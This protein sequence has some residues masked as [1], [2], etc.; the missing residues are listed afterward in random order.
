VAS[1]KLA[2]Y[3]A[4][5]DF[6][7]T[8]E[9]SGRGGVTPSNRLRFVI[10]KHDATRLHYDFRLELDGVFKSWA[11]TKGPSLDPHD[12]R[13][14]V[15]VEDHP[16]DYGD[17][18]GTIPKG[19]Y[20]GGTVQLWDRGYWEV[21]GPG[22]AEEGLAKGDLKIKL[23]G[24]RLKGSW[25][26]VRMKTDRFKGKRTNWL[27]IKHHDG[28][29]REGDADAL[30]AEDRSVASGR[31][32]ADIAAGK[33]RPP[34]PFMLKGSAA[35]EPDAVWDSKEGS[36]AE[37]RAAGETS[38]QPPARKKA[39]PKAE[40]AAAMP[41]FVAPQLCTLLERP[42]SG[43]GWI[44]EI[45]FDGYRMQLRVEDGAAI[46]RTRKGL[47]WTQRFKAVA[48]SGGGLPDCLID[49][50]IVALDHNGAPDF[51]A[52]Q[53]ALSDGKTDELVFF[54]FDL[55]FAEGEDLR[56]SPLSERKARLQALLAAA[57]PGDARLRYVDHFETGGDA[58]LRSA[59]R[60][61]L[62]GIVSKRLDAPYRS[63][64]GE[65]WTKS[66]CRAG[67][68]VVIGGWSET[69]GR[70][71]SLLV[72]VH[73]GGHLIYVGRVGT[74]YGQSVVKQLLPRLKEQEA[75]ESPFSGLNAPRP[76]REVHW[77][78]PDLVAEIEF[79]GWTGDGMVRQAAFKGLREDKPA[80]EVEAET[81]AEAAKTPLATPKAAAP[82][83]PPSS[84]VM[85][86]PISKPD[87]PLWPDAGDGRAVTKL[88]LA[89]YYE[90]VGPW[91]IGHIKGRP[92][93]IVRA[94]DG[95]GGERFFQRHAMPGSSH[96]LELTT[97]SG[98]RKPYLQID[99]VEGLAAV[100][101]VGAVEL[102]PWN[103]RPG[104]PDQ[105][106]RFVFDLDPAPDLPF[107][108][109]IE[110]AL[111][112]RDR[113]DAVGL[114]GFCKTTGGK[115]LHIVTPVAAAKIG[116]P[117]AKAFA[118]E[119]CAQMAAD[120]PDRYLVTMAKKARSGRIFLDYLRN[121]RM[122][123]AVAVLSPRA[124]DGATVSM[125]LLWAEVKKGLDPKAFTIRTAP[126]LIAKS[127][128][129][130]DYADGERPLLAAMKKL[131]G[132]KHVA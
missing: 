75:A 79:A 40:P 112:L 47:D 76:E 27:L 48:A 3:E 66:K 55:L 4:K 21:D 120:S 86:V 43:P 1:S 106:G 103:C 19:Q 56:A 73:R 9:P 84:V 77:L 25:V 107:E 2:D 110:A 6:E 108:R 31:K 93:S 87:K 61:S 90:A 39:K 30:L 34:K 125:P 22:T 69:A 68:E 8:A 67:H 85:G 97:V 100:A 124:R 59:C 98:D 28:F 95:I 74:G 80:E 35:F 118:R 54:A 58:V 115:G 102:H 10:Q 114:V 132:A 53:A 72:G 127:Q 24:A 104:H 23:D 51:A 89:R 81:P 117:D 13:L 131:V 82:A 64:R 105:P 57:K 36:A 88:D 70:F 26:L 116:W 92:C 96:L 65:S 109:V 11:V 113:L 128:A 62:E 94:P 111:E 119:I 83:S 29:E 121:D 78:N 20:G 42:A 5:R 129:W 32:M 15:E 33:G 99:R 38:K 45:K 130:A 44:H 63:G 122:A 46:L 14:A 52:L 18:E 41:D 12:K 49:G 91:M 17:F 50:E 37:L 126:E 60:M 7:K 123:T 16:L 71:R 101:Q